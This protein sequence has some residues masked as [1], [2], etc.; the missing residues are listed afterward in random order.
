MILG[1]KKQFVPLILLGR[2][3]HTIREDRNDRWKEGRTIHFATGVRTKQYKQFF[4]GECVSVEQIIIVN[5]GNH[6][7]IQVSDGECGVHNDCVDYGLIKRNH[8]LLS[9][10]SANDG[11]SQAEFIEWFV[12]NNGD[13][14]SGK[15][16]HWTQHKYVVPQ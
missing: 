16:I 3:I 8:N 7:Y 13:K 1:F 11:L 15:I 12:P 10:V 9:E 4:D 14:F 2:K 6:I 5:H